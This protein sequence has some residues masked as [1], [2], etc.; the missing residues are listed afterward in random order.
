MLGFLKIVILC[1]IV[2]IC[3]KMGRLK[4]K[5]YNNRVV[6]LKNVKN[7]LEILKS[8]IEFTYEPIK[9]I[10]KEISQMVYENRENIFAQT[11]QNMEKCSITES[12]NR[13]V[14]KSINLNQED[15]STIQMFGKL[16][17][18]TDKNRTNQRNQRNQ[19]VA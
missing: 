8:K 11:L 18:K 9:E 15:K 10:F 7:A 6:E 4:A 14:E 16:L 2:L 13:A 1:L 19:P 3:T 5:T 17:G 12:W